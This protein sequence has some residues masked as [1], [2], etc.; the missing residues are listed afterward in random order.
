M[1][2]QVTLSIIIV[3]YNVKDLLINCIK[4]IK[5]TILN[6]TYE[7][8]VVDNNSS[9]DSVQALKS[10]FNDLK[11]ISNNKNVGFA[12]ANNQAIKICCGEYLLFLNPDTIVFDN[13]IN[14][15]LTFFK[16]T[17][18]AGLVSC[19]ILNPDKSLQSSCRNKPSIINAIIE[20]FGLYLLLQKLNLFSYNYLRNWAHNKTR[21]V[22]TVLGAFMLLSKKVIDQVGLLDENFFFYGEEVDWCLRIRDHGLK[23]YFVP[24]FQIIHYGGA[25]SKE[26]PVTSYLNLVKSRKIL[27]KKHFRYFSYIIITSIYIL[28]MVSRYIIRSTFFRSKHYKNNIMFLKGIKIMLQNN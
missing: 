21:S 23:V 12:A 8:I 28:G 25:S 3:S 1:S 9:D 14:G 11:I 15:C 6:T 7:I 27:F 13:T 19:K 10:V 4:S 26:I 5:K 22:P 20:N 2:H 16:D 24:K 18:D 17:P